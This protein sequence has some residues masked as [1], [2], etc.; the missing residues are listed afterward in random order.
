MEEESVLNK[1]NEEILEVSVDLGNGREDVIKVFPGDNIEALVTTFCKRHNLKNTL[2][3]KLVDQIKKSLPQQSPTMSPPMPHPILSPTLTAGKSPLS[4]SS[5][6]ITEY[7]GEHSNLSPVSRDPEVYEPEDA[8]NELLL[9]SFNTY[10]GTDEKS[11]EQ[12]K[13]V[14]SVCKQGKDLVRKENGGVSGIV[15]VW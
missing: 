12:K 3:N 1:S 11:V 8:A 15:M 14:Q 13:H 9:K 2:Q 5:A 6:N 4:K 7:A 10:Y